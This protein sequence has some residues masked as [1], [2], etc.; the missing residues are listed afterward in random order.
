VVDF[1]PVNEVQA[2]RPTTLARLLSNARKSSARGNLPLT[3]AD[4]HRGYDV[5][6]SKG[7]IEGNAAAKRMVAL[8]R[9]MRKRTSCFRTFIRI[10]RSYPRST[11]AR[12]AFGVAGVMT[13]AMIAPGPEAFAANKPQQIEFAQ[14]VAQ[15]DARPTS[16][17]VSIPRNLLYIFDLTWCA[18]WRFRCMSCEKTGGGIKCSDRKD[19]CEETFAYYRCERFV[20]PT[21]CVRWRDGCN[22]CD[23]RYC[24]LSNCPEYLAPN[25]PSFECLRYQS[26][27][28]KKQ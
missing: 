6:V 19:A 14:R 8:E 4:A 26:D 3:T 27:A 20:L 15:A 18:R 21:G 23:K 12:I 16:S 24:T 7:T 5:P 25:R 11:S 22:A 13:L 1:A 28:N 17:Q 10:L 2:F 9:N